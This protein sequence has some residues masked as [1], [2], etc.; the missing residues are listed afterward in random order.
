MRP[1]SDAVRQAILQHLPGDAAL[2]VAFSG[3][4]D[5]TVLLH[6]LARL[7]DERRFLLRAVHVNHGLQPA[8]GDWASH[9]VAAAGALAVPC[10]ALSVTVRNDRGKGL[11]AAAREAR[12]GALREDLEPG[13]WLLTAHHAD[14]QLE[15]VLLHLFRGSGPSGLA[16]IPRG[17]PF[18]AGCLCRPLLDV[19]GDSLAAYAAEFL[20][21]EGL[22]WLTDPMNA[23]AGYD[24]GF[25]R[26]EVAP[27]LRERFPAAAGAVG[28]A[29]SLAA[30]AAG[31]LDELARM[32]AQEVVSANRLSL[33]ALNRRSPARQRNLI[34]MVVRERNWSTPPERR[35]R[36][37]LAQLVDAAPG[38]QPVL[39]WGGH[40]IRRFREHLHLLD[41]AVPVAGSVAQPTPW[42]PGQ[43]L[44][45]GGIRGELELRH[46]TG[47][48]GLS[49]LPVADGL[50]VVFRTGGERVRPGSDRHHR[51]LKYLFQ[52]RGVVPWMRA[53]V[54][55]V[56]ARGRLA[57]V[58][59]LWVADWA[60][61]APGDAGLQIVW[62]GHAPIW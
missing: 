16:G 20:V 28:R 60:A 36:E 53:H 61:A 17:A 3:G 11:E 50:E 7:R 9:C 44:E 57:A 54:P 30:E 13:E 62:T 59:D 56:F 52:S 37:G 2:C 12:Y 21:P 34:R 47:S 1:E 49:P 10:Q 51:T 25:I 43:R 26:H 23:D 15:T 8:A 35:L 18:G 4:R 48:A 38:R 41:V 27:V 5:S 42:S 32:D 45:L 46:G 33:A 22:G 31:L 19:G 58:G 24:R 14:D 40:E 6:A 39:A 29:A 55:L